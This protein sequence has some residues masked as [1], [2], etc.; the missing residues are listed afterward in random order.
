MGVEVYFPLAAARP[1]AGQGQYLLGLDLGQ[2]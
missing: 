1:R 2:A